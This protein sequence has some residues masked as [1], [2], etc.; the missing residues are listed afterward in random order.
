MTIEKLEEFASNGDKHLTGLDVATGFPRADKPE[1][2]WF[3]KLFGDITGK[4]N[5][6]VDSI[7]ELPFVDGFLPTTKSTYL[8]TAIGSVNRTLHDKLKDTVSVEDFGAKGDG[9]TDDTLAVQAAID[10]IES[11][12][13]GE[14][15]FLSG[16]YPC[17]VSINNPN[18]R[19][20]GKGKVLLRAA[21][22]STVLTVQLGGDNFVSTGI[23]YSGQTKENESE[24]DG[25]RNTKAL[26]AIALYGKN[27]IFRDFKAYGARQDGI[28]VKRDG[29]INALFE[30]F[31]IGST[32][33]NPFSLISGKGLTFNRGKFYIDNKYG[34]TQGS[35]VTGLYLFD[36]EPN[37]ETDK[38]NDLKFNDVDFINAGTTGDNWQV[39]FYE[40]NVD[41][42]NDLKVVM[43]NV[44]F[45]KQGAAETP[46]QIRLISNLGG[47]FSGMTLDN[48][49]AD[50]RVFSI[51]GSATVTLEKSRISN[52]T[53]GVAALG[54]GTF[55]GDGV[56]LENI[57]SRATGAIALQ[58]YDGV[59]IKNVTGVP[60]TTVGDIIQKGSSVVGGNFNTGHLGIYT[61]LIDIT[62][63]ATYTDIV[64][65]GTRGTFKITIAGADT[66][67]GARSQ[68]ISETYI[69]VSNDYSMQVP[70]KIIL[71]EVLSGLD[72]KWK[73]ANGYT[74]ETRTLQVKA[75]D[76]ASNIFVVKVEALTYFLPPIGAP[77][78]WLT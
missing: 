60:D 8:N 11:L 72:V 58:T 15:N 9:V 26:H 21:N 36:C 68:H 66:T 35:L 53:L 17:S 74:A 38:Y 14:I 43:N 2:P 10:H 24:V 44:R 69:C 76:A 5:E 20:T 1:R 42:T 34:S 59:T 78:T 73:A 19:F 23:S 48:I 67:G 39:R 47:K 22:T 63:T 70:P 28:Y 77:V 71:D 61:K 56:S 51:A 13:G 12:G 54:Y 25:T 57:R 3:N 32:A 49:Y 46:A 62:N 6:V 31:Y 41:T 33:R 64:T 27:P 52:V 18:V 50:S 40:T 29:E 75:R 16:D 4:I 65:V 37:F 45:L 30:D 7:D 55:V